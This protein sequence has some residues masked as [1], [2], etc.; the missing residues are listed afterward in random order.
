MQPPKNWRFAL[1]RAS[2]L[3]AQGVGIAIGA[4]FFFLGQSVLAS[5]IVGIAWAAGVLAS[6]Y[7]RRKIQGLEVEVSASEARISRIKEIMDD[8]IWACKE[9]AHHASQAHDDGEVHMHEVEGESLERL[10]KRMFPEE[11]E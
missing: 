8:E 9:A 7:Q 5:V 2:L 1:K 6:E 11:C 10:F 4:G 3:K